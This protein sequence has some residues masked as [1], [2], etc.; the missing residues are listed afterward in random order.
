MRFEVKGKYDYRSGH[1]DDLSFNAGQVIVVTEEVDEEWYQGEYTDNDGRLRQGMFP[2]NFVVASKPQNAAP[3]SG[4]ATASKREP[5]QQPAQAFSTLPHSSIQPEQ[6]PSTPISSP[7]ATR[8]LATP[9]SS[10]HSDTPVT[11][12]QPVYAS[13]ASYR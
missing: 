11:P 6:A 12:P 5:G 9:L 7:P 10:P 8:T 1:E 3:V 4:S 2:R 13:L